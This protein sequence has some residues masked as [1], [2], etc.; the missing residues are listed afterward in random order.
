MYNKKIQN[1]TK[2]TEMYFFVLSHLGRKK[3]CCPDN[4]I[5]A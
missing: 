5:S 2:K 1:K 4:D 3:K